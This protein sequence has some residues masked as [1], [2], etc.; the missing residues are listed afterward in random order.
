METKNE[1]FSEKLYFLERFYIKNRKKLI[2]LG[3]SFILGGIFYFIKGMVEDYQTEAINQAYFKYLQG[4]NAEENLNIIKQTNPKLYNLIEFSKVV[5]SN[6]PDDLKPFLNINDPII[7]DLASYQIAVLNKDEKALN[8]YSFKDTA[9][10]KDLAII[11]DSY[12]LIK[13]GKTEEATN[14]LSFIENNSEVLDLS[15]LLVHLGVAKIDYNYNSQ[16]D[17]LTQNQVSQ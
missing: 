6:N 15:K 1:G 9:L 10:F 12:S 11:L 2:I 8:D 16:N 13:S 4:E 14:R 7:S 3:G 5:K 17:K